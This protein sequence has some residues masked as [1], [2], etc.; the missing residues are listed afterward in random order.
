MVTKVNGTTGVDAPGFA[1]TGTPGRIMTQARRVENSA[2]TAINATISV[3]AAPSGAAGTDILTVQVTPTKVGSLIV[4]DFSVILCPAAADWVVA[5]CFANG[6][7]WLATAAHYCGGTDWGS[8]ISASGEFVSTSLS[9]VT[10]VVR[11]GT[12]AGGALRVNSNTANPLFPGVG[13]T[14]ITAKEYV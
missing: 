14:Y 1:N 2:G 8:T 13:R 7:S 10:I 11:V 12:N 5:H 9:P 3:Y 4:V 6:T